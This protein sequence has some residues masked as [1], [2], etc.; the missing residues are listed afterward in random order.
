[1]LDKLGQLM[2]ASGD[3]MQG[4]AHELQ[5]LAT[6][7]GF[8]PFSLFT[9]E[10]RVLGVFLAP[11][12]PSLETAIADYLRDGSGPLQQTV[13]QMHKEGL[14][15]ATARLRA[16]E[17]FSAARGMCVVV[18]AHDQGLMT[19]PQLAFERINADYFEHLLG[20]FTDSFPQRDELS[21]LFTRLFT[22]LE[23][24]PAFPET[25]VACDRQVSIQEFW[26]DL[27]ERLI[28]SLDEGIMPGQAQQQ[29]DLAWWTLTACS[30]LAGDNWDGHD[31]LCA[32]RLACHADRPE[33]ACQLAARLLADFEPEDEETLRLCEALGHCAIRVGRPQLAS[34]FY[35]AHT[36]AFDALFGGPLYELALIRLRCRAAAQASLEE[37]ISATEALRAAD[38][39]AFRHDLLR[40]PLWFVTIPEPGPLLDTADAAEQIGRSVH[41]IAK[42]LDNRTLPLVRSGDQLRIP[43][44]GLLNWHGLMEHFQL[45][46]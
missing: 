38:R 11:L 26:R 22:A 37:L 43:Q 20:A 16:R 9:G 19:V 41:F 15:E 18:L 45:L 8:D 3:D 6:G 13:A 14:D 32:A 28:T 27:G 7:G 35:A 34:D 39:K 40:E 46:D 10:Q 24:S 44:A 36:A 33:E 17:L 30:L 1:M 23:R 42:R 25:V 2:N 29:G 12:T 5:G 4:F 31:L 21:R